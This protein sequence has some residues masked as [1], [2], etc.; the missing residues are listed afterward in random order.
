MIETERFQYHVEGFPLG[1]LKHCC[2]DVGTFQ[3]NGN[4][5]YSHYDGRERVKTQ[6]E[7]RLIVNQERVQCFY[8][9]TTLQ[10]DLQNA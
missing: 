7:D 9:Y 6:Y 8:R 4:A 10:N 1:D 5:R 2:N 3:T